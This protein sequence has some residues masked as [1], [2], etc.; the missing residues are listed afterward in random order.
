MSE[1]RDAKKYSDWW[2]GSPCGGPLEGKEPTLDFESPPSYKPPT[3]LVNHPSHYTE[4]GIETIDVIEAW[5]L[6]FC[7]GNAIKY[8]S[9]AGKKDS[10][11]ELE[12]LRKA[13]W[14]LN[15]AIDKRRK[16]V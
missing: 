5:K 14:Y 6:D 1:R 11:K 8:I 12:D 16:P 2:T 3:D 13:Q 15:R 9:R 7:L 10:S 4:S